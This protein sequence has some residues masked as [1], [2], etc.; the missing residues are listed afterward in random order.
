MELKNKKI[1]FLGD[2][3]T[4]GCGTSSIEHVFW[5]VIAQRTGAQCF[6]YGIGGTRI[7]PQRFM[8]TENPYET[9]YFASRVDDMIPDADIVVV[10]GGTNDYGH[11][12]AA[13][14]QYSDRTND[15][16]Y[17]AYHLL[18][19]KLIHRYPNAQLVVMTPLHRTDDDTR[20]YNERG[21]RLNGPL[22]AYVQA[23]REV[24]ECYGVAVVDLYR[25]CGI[26]PNHPVHKD[27]YAPDGLHPNDAGHLLVAQCV[28]NV[29][30]AL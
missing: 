19:E 23:I 11:G 8:I 10:F 16:F 29:L 21:L 27:R 26:Q 9:L 18:L 20:I 12:D 30:K 25:D 17:G 3:I 5:N 14:G 7:A 6:G 24:A 22:S 28:L 2:S 4:E 13:L 15:T 1:A